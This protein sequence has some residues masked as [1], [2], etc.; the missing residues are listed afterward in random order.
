[1]V[2]GLGVAGAFRD[3]DDVRVVPFLENEELLQVR[4]HARSSL[5]RR[6]EDGIAGSA[7]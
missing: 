3:L 6:G 7:G 2:K 1:L 4:R 5:C